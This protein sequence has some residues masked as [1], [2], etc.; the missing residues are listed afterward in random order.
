MTLDGDPNPPMRR[1]ER[2]EPQGA[3]GRFSLRADVCEWPN[4]DRGRY[5]VFDG[6]SSVLVVPLFEDGRTVLVRQWRYPWDAASWEVV[7]GTREL[8]ED[9]PDCAV[10]EL[11]EEA[12]LRAQRWTPLGLVRPTATT[13]VT[14]HVFLAQ[15]LT[16]TETRL[17]TYERDM[18]RREIPLREA[19]AA[20]LDGVIVHAGSVSALSRVSRAVGLI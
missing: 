5:A 11:E 14:Q 7:A 4:G 3:V 19:L 8:D 15:G 12:G 1:I 16:R 6:P 2:G 18:I 10:R 9:P 17:E 20:A 13:T